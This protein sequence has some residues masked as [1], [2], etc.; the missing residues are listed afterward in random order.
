MKKVDPD[1]TGTWDGLVYIINEDKAKTIII[2][3]NGDDFDR[4]FSLNDCLAAI[5]YKEGVVTVI[6][7]DFL[8]GKVYRYNNYELNSWYEIGV[9]EGYA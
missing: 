7:E 6:I 1:I 5:D 8:K 9:T 4:F 2:T 3:A